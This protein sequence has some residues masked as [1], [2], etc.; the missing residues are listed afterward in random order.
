MDSCPWEDATRSATIPL[1]QT[2]LKD[3]VVLITGASGGIG[4]ACTSPQT[5][6]TATRVTRVLIFIYISTLSHPTF[7]A[8]GTL[9]LAF[10]YTYETGEIQLQAPAGG[11]ET[12]AGTPATDPGGS[13]INM[14]GAGPLA[15]GSK[16]AGLSRPSRRWV[17]QAAGGH[18]RPMPT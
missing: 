5:L 9:Y 16:R 15:E 4:A 18:P 6:K 7:S 13:R 8:A 14:P 11:E 10:Q 2:D 1:M 12:G 3:K 17:G